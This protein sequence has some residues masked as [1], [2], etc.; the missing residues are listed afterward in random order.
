MTLAD[1][2]GRKRGGEIAAARCRAAYLAR[3]LFRIPVRR[4][5]LRL[6]RDDSSFARPLA[7]LQCRLPF[8][9]ALQA[10]IQRLTLLLRTAAAA[11]PKS[12]IRTDPN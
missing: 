7:K 8:D 12:G 5:A 6:G 2:Q 4:V 9:Q 10:R 1:L 11:T 3:Q